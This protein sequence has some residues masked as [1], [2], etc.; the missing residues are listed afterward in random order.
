MG[1]QLLKKNGNFWQ[2]DGHITPRQFTHWFQKGQS[3][4]E[5]VCSPHITPDPTQQAVFIL[6]MF[7]AS[8]SIWVWSPCHHHR[9]PGPFNNI[10]S[11][12]HSLTLL[13]IRHCSYSLSEFAIPWPKQSRSFSPFPAPF[14]PPPHFKK[15]FLWG[16][17]QSAHLIRLTDQCFIILPGL[18]CW[19]LTHS[20]RWPDKMCQ[21]MIPLVIE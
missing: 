13:R 11:K 12:E 9:E 3:P 7:Q 17:L 20:T 21:H 18:A 16:G 14:P 1:F 15:T 6:H 5:G 4:S 2:N 10:N 8:I 19:I